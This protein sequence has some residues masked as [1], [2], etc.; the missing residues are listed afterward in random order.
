MMILYYLAAVASLVCWILVLIQIFKHQ[1]IALGVIG[2]LCPIVAFIFGW[3]KATEWR[4]MNIMLA[5]TGCIVLQI[6]V[7]IIAGA[8][9][10]HVTVR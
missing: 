6:I 1:Q 8:F 10:A 5:W 2:I 3:I 9:T 4:I 7:G